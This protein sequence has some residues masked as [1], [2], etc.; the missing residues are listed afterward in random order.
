VRHILLSFVSL[1]HVGFRMARYAQSATSLRGVW[2]LSSRPDVRVQ[3]LGAGLACCS[4]EVE[5]AVSTGQLVPEEPEA[6]DISTADEITANP[7]QA[8]V[9]VVAGTITEALE[10]ALEAL[11]A[12]L[13]QRGPVRVMSFG[14]CATS[15]G[16]YWDAPTVA[17]GIRSFPVASYVPGCPPRPEALVAELERIVDSMV[18]A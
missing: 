16:P 10:P 13:T 15:G 2:R 8:T 18:S 3:I 5:A 6:V 11:H 7:P 9:L 12:E 17:K 1:D 4:L 14:A